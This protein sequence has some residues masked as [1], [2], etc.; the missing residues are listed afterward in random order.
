MRNIYEDSINNSLS[1]MFNANKDYLH[2]EM[3]RLGSIY[4]RDPDYKRS[5]MLYWGA[6]Q[7]QNYLGDVNFAIVGTSTFSSTKVGM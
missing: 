4:E 7:M 2:Q 5:G 6:L 3:I 1:K